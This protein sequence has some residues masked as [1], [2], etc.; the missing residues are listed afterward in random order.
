MSKRRVLIPL[1][2]S[3]FSRQIL[4]VVKN[5]F[6]PEDVELIL[7]RAAYP[8]VLPSEA[9]P[10]D[11]FMGGMP[12]SGTYEAYNRAMDATYAAL[13]KERE[14][15]R[16]QLITEIQPELG[17]LRDAG[18]VV[19]AQV[20]YGEPAQCII[21]YVNDTGVDLV[22]MATHGRG[23]LGRLVLGSVAERVLRSVGVP[24]L[25]MRPGTVSTERGAA[26]AVLART[27]GNSAHMR[28]AAATDGSPAAQHALQVTAR[29]AD[30]LKT[31]MSVLVVAPGQADSAQAQAIMSSTWSLV[32]ETDPKP[33]LVPLVGYTDDVL[34]T[35]LEKNPQDLLVVGPFQDRGAGSQ[36][37]IGPS[38][39][40]LVQQATT[41]VM[42]V[43][44]HR[45]V[46]KRILV[47]AD[48]DD[49]AAVAVGSQLAA[50]LHAGL[51]VVHVISPSAASYLS[52][53]HSGELTLDEALAQGTRLSSVLQGWIDRLTADGFTRNALHLRQG[54]M[55]EAALD[56][57]HSG[58][59]DLV[60][61]GSRAGAG[62]FS[63]SAA[64]NM[65]RYAECS[66]LVV[67]TRG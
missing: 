41:S 45:V 8:P 44:G 58:Q 20:D 67:R 42:V 34:L 9:A 33:E 59:Y 55:P 39:Q 6:E 40:R 7:F 65:V 26:A 17:R 36:S 2:G 66:V 56:L 54:A 10:A 1:D 47:C 15:F 35:W 28:L 62:H 19:R 63:G 12:L 46:T 51:D 60:I 13:D 22:A 4:R 5:F 31:R 21:D 11:M 57:A 52:P 43:K 25:L 29:L 50:A 30:V 16:T 3:D 27:L 24:V 14:Q 64:S 48:V 37:A 23:G 32:G 18:Y 53:G 61:V 38:A 49:D